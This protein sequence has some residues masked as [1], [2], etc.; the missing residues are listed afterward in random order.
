MINANESIIKKWIASWNSHDVEKIASFYT[1]DCVHE[2]IAVGLIHHGKKELR[3]SLPR[4]FVWIP[5]VNMSLIS[6][7][8]DGSHAASEWIMSGTHAGSLPGIPAT[9]KRF[10][11]KGASISVLK[12]G[13]IV[14][15]CDYWNYASFLQQVGLMSPFPLK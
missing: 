9:G 1:D 14:R 6:V 2:D 10:S 13:K 12:K 5:D 7:F 4:L 8:V 11:V 15:N 3:D